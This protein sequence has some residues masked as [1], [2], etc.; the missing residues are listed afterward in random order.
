MAFIWAS[1][2]YQCALEVDIF[3]RNTSQSKSPTHIIVIIHTCFQAQNCRRR[4]EMLFF[5]MP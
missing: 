2:I 1:R 4:F 5:T 3:V